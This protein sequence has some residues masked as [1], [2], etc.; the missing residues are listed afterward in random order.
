MGSPSSLILG[1]EAAADN[2]VLRKAHERDGAAFTL[3]RGDTQVLRVDPAGNATVLT[4]PLQ[5]SGAVKAGG[6]LE[7][8]GELLLGGVR[9]SAAA[10]SALLLNAGPSPPP[11]VTLIIGG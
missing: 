3:S 9:L 1:G 8:G 7:A 5:V 6:N 2:V 11:P 10:L 4:D